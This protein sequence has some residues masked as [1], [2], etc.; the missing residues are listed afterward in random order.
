MGFGHVHEKR[1]T[2]LVCSPIR[3]CKQLGLS[4]AMLCRRANKLELVPGTGFN[5]EKMDGLCARLCDGI[6]VER[7][8]GDESK[9]AP[10]ALVSARV[11]IAEKKIILIMNAV[12][13]LKSKLKA[14]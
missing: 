9:D 5:S 13:A 1:R 12:T 10:T 6:T 2:L 8:T 7:A 4:R 14:T 11:S 3:S